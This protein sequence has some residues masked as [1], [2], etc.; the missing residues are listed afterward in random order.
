MKGRGFRG[1]AVRRAKAWQRVFGWSTAHLRPGALDAP[2]PVG[3]VGRRVNAENRAWLRAMK[4]RR[5]ARVEAAL[6]AEPELGLS[7]A[8]EMAEAA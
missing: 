5:A 3:A 1:L 7:L 4:R 6:M 8:W 2:E